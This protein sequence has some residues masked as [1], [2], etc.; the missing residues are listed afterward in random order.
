MATSDLYERAA[1]FFLIVIARD[2]A[3]TGE[4]RVFHE[5]RDA[6]RAAS[7]HSCRDRRLGNFIDMSHFADPEL[8]HDFARLLIAPFIDLAPLIFR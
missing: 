3:W 8:V 1:A 2:A 4:L 7:R 5:L 6:I